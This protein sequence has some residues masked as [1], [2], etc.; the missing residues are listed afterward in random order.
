MAGTSWVVEPQND[1]FSGIRFYSKFKFTETEY[2]IANLAYAI[3]GTKLSEYQDRL[4]NKKNFEFD[5]DIRNEKAAMLNNW[6]SISIADIR[7]NLG[8]S[9]KREEIK[10]ALYK[11]MSIQMEIKYK[12]RESAK[13]SVFVSGILSSAIKFSDNKIDFQVSGFQQLL[14][15]EAFRNDMFYKV[16]N[17]IR[18]YHSKNFDYRGLNGL[19]PSQKQIIFYL[20]ESFEVMHKLRKDK[21]IVLTFSDKQIV[22]CRNF[23][24][25]G[26][27]ESEYEYDETKIKPEHN[28]D[29]SKIQIK[30]DLKKKHKARIYQVRKNFKKNI[31]LLANNDKWKQFFQLSRDK[32]SVV[33]HDFT[34]LTDKVKYNPCKKIEFQ[35]IF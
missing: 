6:F 11:L 24:I 22:E 28:N 26:W 15:K 16:N 10:K 12:E 3:I 23:D 25:Y 29:E 21:S 1:L 32:K 8:G 9:Y 18:K 4:F 7:K 2:Q 19:K 13:D 14:F 20:A 5:F 35:T 17:S 34:R 27:L 33:V 30:N 31:K